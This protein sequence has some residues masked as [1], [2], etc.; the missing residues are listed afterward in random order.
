[1]GRI[2][3]LAFLMG[4][5]CLPKKRDREIGPDLP[6]HFAFWIFTKTFAIEQYKMGVS[7]S[8][9]YF[10]GVPTNKWIAKESRGNLL[11]SFL[12]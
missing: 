12:H 9:E 3:T 8:E 6:Y 2:L 1:M 10:L 11:H 4:L 7:F 5:S